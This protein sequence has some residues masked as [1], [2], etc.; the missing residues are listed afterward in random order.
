MSKFSEF[1][2]VY[3]N[4][5]IEI[6]DFGEQRERE[7]RVLIKSIEAEKEQMRQTIIERESTMREDRKTKLKK[8]LEDNPDLDYDIAV[9]KFNRQYNEDMYYNNL[10]NRQ[11]LMYKQEKQMLD[12]LHNRNIGGI[13]H[14]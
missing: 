6:K 9:I 10:E 14:G 12:R 5:D 4:S 8:Y 1:I 2:N 11:D 3:E 7:E 13:K